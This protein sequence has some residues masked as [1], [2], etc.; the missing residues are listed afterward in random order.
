MEAEKK[1]C[2]SCGDAPADYVY[3][4]QVRCCECYQELQYGKLPKPSSVHFC[5]NG[6]NG[7]GEPS[8]WQENA[9]REMEDA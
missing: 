2:V 7:L 1:V 4:C 5:G 6:G 8:P 3:R 9:I